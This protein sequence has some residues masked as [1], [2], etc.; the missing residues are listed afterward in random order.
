MAFFGLLPD[1]TPNTPEPVAA[2]APVAATPVATPAPSPAPMHQFND[3]WQPVAAPKDPDPTKAGNIFSQADPTKMLEAARGVNFVEG[4]D[5]NLLATAAKGGPEGVAAMVQIINDVG[6]RSYAQAAFA[7]TR[8]V[9]QGLSQF[10]LGLDK[11]LPG[12]IKKHTVSESIVSDNPAFNNPAL[13]PVIQAVQLQIQAKH[14]QATTAEIRAYTLQ[15]LTGMSELIVNKKEDQ[16]AGSQ[17]TG[18]TATDNW[19]AF[20]AQG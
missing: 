11:S 16:Q 19:E 3:L 18:N 10:Q 2:P 5:A 9:D 1:K 6:Q 7:S 12:A 13:A 8:V 15:Y 20:F 14:P 4:L 17:T